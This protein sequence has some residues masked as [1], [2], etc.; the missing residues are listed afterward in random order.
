MIDENGVDLNDDLANLPVRVP[1]D[2]AAE[3]VKR[4]FFHISP[5]T[6]E[7]WPLKW[8]LLNG[9]AHVETCELFAVAELRLVAAPVIAG[10]K[11]PSLGASGRRSQ[12]PE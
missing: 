7:R 2:A 5:R 12:R 9:R 11:R 3:L 4:Y 6:L 8:R 1:R 10:G